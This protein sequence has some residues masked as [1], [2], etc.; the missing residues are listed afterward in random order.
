MDGNLPLQGDPNISVIEC[1]EDCEF[2]LGDIGDLLFSETL[3]YRAGEVLILGDCLIK[4]SSQKSRVED[5]PEN[6]TVIADHAFTENHGIRTVSL[7]SGLKRIGSQAF[8]DCLNLEQIELPAGLT[9]I[10]AAAFYGCKSLTHI[11]LPASVEYMESSIFIGCHSLTDLSVSTDNPFYKVED[12]ALWDIK[13]NRLLWCSSEAGK[14]SVTNGKVRYSLEIPDA[15]KE[16]ASGAFYDCE[17]LEELT[18]PDL[19][20]INQTNLFGRCPSLNTVHISDAN[21]VFR[22]DGSLIYDKIGELLVLCE[23]DTVGEVALTEGTLAINDYAFACCK[24]LT[25]IK[26][27][28]TLQ[29]IGMSAFEECTGLKSIVLPASLTRI[30]TNAFLGCTNLTDIYYEGTREEREAM[31]DRFELGIDEK[32]T[33]IRTK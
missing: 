11:T 22:S 20:S 13:D 17:K 7:P 12:G 25:Q 2:R 31:T 32:R 4:Y 5:I 18:V 15:I 6:V 1:P 33:T 3:W 26:L 27:P 10:D 8:Q 23:R 24:D 21:H 28:K 16:I 14:H 30:A 19:T 9:Q 29:F